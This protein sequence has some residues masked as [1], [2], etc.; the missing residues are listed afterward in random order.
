MSEA[1]QSAPTHAITRDN[2]NGGDAFFG[3]WTTTASEHRVRAS[4]LRS[5]SQQGSEQA[6]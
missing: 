6:A 3:T 4:P 1:E 5:C 2:D